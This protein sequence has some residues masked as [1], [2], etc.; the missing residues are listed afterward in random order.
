MNRKRWTVR[1]RLTV[2]NSAVLTL[3]FCLFSVA[4]LLAVH[5]HLTHQADQLMQE[6][7]RELLEDF[8][9][10][11][12]DPAVMARQLERRFAVHADFHF[13]VLGEDLQP[14]FRSRYLT[15]LELPRPGDPGTIRGQIFQDVNLPV[16]NFRM[17]TI[18]IRDARS[19][20]L[21]LQ[22]ITPRSALRQEFSWYWGTLLTALPAAILVSI[23][24]GHLLARQALRPLDQMAATATRISAEN[25]NE[26]LILENPRDELGRLTVT[27]N[28]MFDRLQT[29]MAQMK[30]FTSDAAHE[31]RSPLAALKTRLEVTLRSER[32]QAS[33]REIIQE[34][35]EE[36]NH[37]SKLVDQLLQLSRHDSGQQTVSFDEVR[38]DVLLMDVAERFQSVADA[39]GMSFHIDALPPW[40]IQGDDIWLSMVFWNLLENASK[41]SQPGG[42]ISVHAEV[43]DSR[44]VCRIRDTGRGIASQHLPRIFDRF[45]RVDASRTRSEG[46]T[47]LGLAICKS[48]VEAHS[49]TISVTS[50]VGVGTEFRIELPGTPVKPDADPSDEDSPLAQ[51]ARD[52]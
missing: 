10:N 9:R 25:L 41:Y 2:W 51:N 35:L 29:S 47:G 45:Y 13:Q 11:E 31:L 20:P 26:R 37:M 33:Y 28:E 8:R 7:L 17:L 43:C 48:I 38:V 34:V 40:S 49:G 4:M 32:S 14:I 18:A 3:L 5:S 24:A 42:E 21:L 23:G 15:N 19:K 39:R 6:E 27:L 52:S 36:S 44:W 16:G 30:Q 22:V 12:D 1:W 46:G 50:E